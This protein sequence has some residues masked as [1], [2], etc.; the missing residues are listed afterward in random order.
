MHV[1]ITYNFYGTSGDIYLLAS[2]YIVV[3]ITKS[4]VTAGVTSIVRVVEYGGSRQEED[5]AFDIFSDLWKN[6]AGEY[7]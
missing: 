1:R 7:A 2:R 6:P 5:I 3:F 4:R